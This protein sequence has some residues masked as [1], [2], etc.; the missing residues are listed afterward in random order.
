MLT[1][2][3]EEEG[4]LPYLAVAYRQLSS[5]IADRIMFIMENL[6]NC[7]Y[8]SGC[9]RLITMVFG[10]NTTGSPNTAALIIDRKYGSRAILNSRITSHI[11]S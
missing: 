4:V 9:C 3:A 8:L 5:K 6:G 10:I 2:P 1:W 7:R 11:L